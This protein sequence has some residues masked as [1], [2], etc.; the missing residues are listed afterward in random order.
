MLDIMKLKSPKSTSCGLFRIVPF[1]LS[2]TASTAMAASSPA[3][4]AA[5]KQQIAELQAKTKQL[6]AALAAKAPSPA[7]PVAAMNSGPQ[8]TPAPAM[9]AMTPSGAPAAIGMGDMGGMPMNPQDNKPTPAVGG[10]GGMMTGMMGMMNQMMGMGA[11]P[12]ASPGMPM[13]PPAIPQSALPG[14]PGVSHLYHIG[15]TGFFLEHAQHIGL[16]ADQQAALTKLKEQALTAKTGTDRQI[17]QAEQEMATLT[18]IDQPDAAKIEA[19]VH[20]IEKLRTD[21][22]LSFISAVG[23]AAKLLTDDQRKVL[24]GAMQTAA[25]SPSASMA[26]MPDM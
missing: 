13:S 16:S 23:E 3:S 2:L 6:E 24:T 22:R 5:L 21:E 18:S 26:P 4:D 20:E 19:K 25:P 14:F 1:V 15:S 10:M 8:V 12:A 9:P 7:S 17:E 11:M